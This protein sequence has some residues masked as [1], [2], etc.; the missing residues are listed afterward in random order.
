MRAGR[1]Q[2]VSKPSPNDRIA[3][4]RAE[5]ERHNRLYYIDATP[6]ISD[7]QYDQKMADLMALEQAHPELDRPDSP[8]H[9]VGGAPIDGF[10][11]IPHRVPM[12]SIDNTYDPTQ[13][14][15][16]DV[17]LR[18]L[19]PL[20]VIEYAVEPKIDGVAISLTYENGV[21]TRG[22]TRGDGDKGDD[23][24]ANLRTVRDLPLRLMCDSPPA[25]VEVRGEIYMRRDD[26]AR[27]NNERQAEGL[28]KFA[29]PRNSTAGSLKLLDPAQC[30]KRRLRLFVYGFGTL[31]GIDFVTHMEALEQFGKW[32]LPVNSHIRLATGIDEV[33]TLISEWDE[34]RASLHYDTDGLVIK[35]NDLASRQKAGFTSKSPRWTVAYKFA[36]EQAV[37][38]LKSI[39]IQVGKTGALTPVANLEPV[40]L[41]GTTVSRASLHNADFIAEKDIRVGDMVVVE[42]AGEI[43]P[44]ISRAEHERRTGTEM[45]FV[46]P[47]A[48]PVCGSVVARDVDGAV[49]RCQ[50]RECVAVLKRRLRAV[51][52]RAAMD[53]AGLG[54]EMVEQLVDSGLVKHLPDLYRL[55]AEQL[56]ALDRMGETSARNLLAGVEASKGR[57]LAR[58]LAGLGIRHVGETVAEVLAGAFGDLATL[59]AADEGAL[60][61]VEG[62][63]PERAASLAAW[64]R[65]TDNQKILQDFQ[66]LGLKVSAEGPKRAPVGAMAGKTFVVTGTLQRFDRLGI[67]RIIKDLGGKVSGSVSKKT[68]F[69]LAGEN[70]GSKL[71]KAQQL[72]VRVISEAEFVDL[73]GL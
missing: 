71:E 12:L 20:T 66:D 8:S 36:A 29:N 2:S 11:T 28:E 1:A 57:G 50:G 47:T 58:L 52:A 68:D 40:Q 22:L 44:Y 6:E 16:F 63:G 48:C 73:A 18:K 43:I 54:E 30:S 41:S 49:W 55:R 33:L 37:T 64:L 34:R 3:V 45:P 27:L 9:K 15:E 51:G 31:E 17:R 13:V 53:V 19:V 59:M 67:E 65:D 4:L 46:F 62:I 60:S 24:T 10:A 21:F 25:L 35:L 39:D 7:H 5:L 42:K 26:F 61:S 14:R 70:A 69:V 32:G 56:E 23:V 72:G 38:L